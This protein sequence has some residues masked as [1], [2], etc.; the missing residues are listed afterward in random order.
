[1]KSHISYLIIVG[2]LFLNL[3]AGRTQTCYLSCNDHVHASLPSDNCFRSFDVE[4][5]LQ[6]PDPACSTYSL[7]IVHPYGTSQLDSNKVDASHLGYT[8]VFQVKNGGNSCWGYVTIE[9][10][11]PPQPFCK[12]STISCFQFNKISEL[13]KVVVDN[14]SE[15]GKSIIEKL[16]WQ[17]YACDSVGIT[18]KV[19]RTIRTIDPWGNSGAC[20]DTLRIR[21]DSFPLIK[22]PDMINLACIMLCKKAGNKESKDD[23]ANFDTFTFSSNKF[24]ANYPSPEKLIELQ[25]RDTFKS[26][27]NKC[28]PA[29]LRV[30]PFIK[31]SV[32]KFINGVCTLVDTCVSM[33]PSTGILCKML[34]R[35][36]DLI[37]PVCGN[38]FKVRREW[39]FTNWCSGQDTICVQYINVEDKV[40]PIVK[41]NFTIPFRQKGRRLEMVIPGYRLN[42]ATNVHDCYATF[43]L[44][45]LK[46]DDCSLH[47]QTY[48]VTY[49]DPSRNGSLTTKAGTLKDCM[50]LPG[51]PNNYLLSD[52]LPFTKAGFED[53]TMPRNCFPIFIQA[54]DEC[55]NTTNSDLKIIDSRSSRIVYQAP[56]GYA[57]VAL[58]CISDE[59]PPNPVCIKTLQ[60]TIDPEQCWSRIYAADLDKGSKDNCCDILH[61]AVANMDSVVYYRSKYAKQMEDSCGKELYWKY[62]P[63]HDEFIEN[64]INCYVF[65]DYVDL[66]ECNQNQLIL[67]AYEACGVPRYDDHIYTCGAHSWF[68]YN[69]YPAFML[70]HNYLKIK[71]NQDVCTGTFPW[72]CRNKHLS[73]MSS[74][75]SDPKE[76]WIPKY[77]GST[78]LILYPELPI[79]TAYCFPEFYFEAAPLSGTDATNAPGNTCSKRLYSDCMVTVLVDDK[80]PPVAINPQ[81]KFW[82][83][84]NVS[85]DE[86]DRY[87]Y[88]R[89]DDE[90]WSMDNAKDK[91]CTDEKGIPYN[92]I[93]SI[94]ENDAYAADTIDPTGKFYGWYG[95]N[96]YGGAHPDEHGG[97]ISC[98]STMNSWAPVY[99][100]SWLILDSTDAAGKV[101]PLQQFDTPIL[102]NGNPGN[103][104][105]GNGHFYIWDNCWMNLSSLDSTDVSYFD[106]CGNGWIKRTWT[107]KDKCG[108][109]VS[110]DQKITTK[111]R[112]DFEVLF[113][114]DKMTLCG[115][116]EDISPEAIGRPIIMDDE[117]ELVGVNYEDQQ[118]DIVPDACYKIIRT[119]R[120]VDWC[121]FDPNQHNRDQDI[122][123]DDRKVADAV[124]RPCVYRHVKDNGDGFVTYSQIILIKDTIRPSI[125]IKDTTICFYDNSCLLASVFIPFSASD[126]CTAPGLIS[127]RWELDETPSASDLANKT[128]NKSSID[129]VSRGNESSLNTLHKIGVSLVHVIAEDNCGNE[130]TTTF[131]LTVRDCKKPTPYCYNG[132]AT[133]I[134]P[135][136]GTIKVWAKDLDAG[137]YDNCTSRANLK[138]TFGPNKGDSCQSFNCKN[139]P[140]GVS[141]TNE[142]DI[143]VWDEAGNVDFCRTFVNIQ[144]GSGDVCDDA[145]SIMSSISGNI[146]TQSAEPVEQVN[147]EARASFYMPAFKTSTTGYY[148]FTNLPLNSNLVL[149]PTKSDNPTNGVSTID[150]LKIQKHILG[151]DPIKDPYTLVAADINNDKDINTNDLIELRKVILNIYDA[152]PSNTSWRFVPKSFQFNAATPFDF[153]EKIDITSL[154]SD[155]INR[156]FVGIKTGDI[157][158]TVIAHSLLGAESR[159]AVASLTFKLVDQNLKKGESKEINFYADDFNSIQAFQFTMSHPD[160]EI[161]GVQGK[162]I[163]MD[164][165]NFGSFNDAM[166]TSWDRVDRTSIRA[167]E[168]LFSITVKAKKDLTLSNQMTINSRITR[169]ES[170]DG[171][172]ALGVALKF[173]SENNK[174]DNRFVLYQNTPNP[175]QSVTRISFELP[176]AQPVQIVITDLT[177]KVIFKQDLNGKKGFNQ[178]TLDKQ[179]S[180][181]GIYYYTL[182]AKGFKDSKK[183]IL[184][185]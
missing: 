69:T 142:V 77:P 171:K 115:N 185:Q 153:P 59:T 99:C 22:C 102:H 91:M 172:E 45:S 44:D 86:D 164:Q 168:A 169:A 119:W 21:K 84:D 17:D 170:Y 61:F 64:W 148:A 173:G 11:A 122:I 145:N 106:N 159:G 146:R 124:K 19:I 166:T 38:G 110:V 120:I 139:I 138:F 26:N 66:T 82:Y 183:M 6:N 105:A 58:V 140:N 184:V 80:T 150:L 60:T 16:I 79:E 75:L 74:L 83:C 55:F 161:L 10:K 5:F 78:R 57:G 157:N 114:Q 135:S 94:K 136:T 48:S 34:L 118:F 177:G 39:T 104:D 107:A 117:C 176:G 95:C 133:V 15:E 175:F 72:Y 152:F 92:Q 53:F 32:F 62:K 163:K 13:N 93:E 67:R 132:I 54:Q 116:M 179:L 85:S 2:I 165:R 87:E 63:F 43:C 143:Y 109:S 51:S 125:T 96:I 28:I 47:H 8:I 112:S 81:D 162:A 65:K 36:D 121:K 23:P 7:N 71:T 134:M 151:L 147:V 31:D 144:D 126:N 123:V 174:S 178:W 27:V 101:N 25:K 103:A 100:R 50:T 113:P 180:G 97:L 56:F 149:K 70:W 73:L 137:S 131:A 14:C 3:N 9:D 40:A 4:D 155:E 30:V 1:M 24:D 167:D 89:C 42:V 12:N 141:F 158:N 182:A 156:D 108:N 111:H 130:D 88:A 127:Y 181:S 154:S 52:N 33:Y 160:L 49:P 76:L 90:S 98:P 29:N 41:T 129:K 37:F 46:T 20:T 18:G 68:C 35:Y 128:Y